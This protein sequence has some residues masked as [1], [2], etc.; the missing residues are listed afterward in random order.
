MRVTKRDRYRDA[1]ARQ[2]TRGIHVPYFRGGGNPTPN[3]G[4]ANVASRE[5]VFRFAL[6]SDSDPG[7]H[8]QSS[9]IKERT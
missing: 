9:T 4:E 3:R 1:I 5:A 6:E 8:F 2:E 7:A